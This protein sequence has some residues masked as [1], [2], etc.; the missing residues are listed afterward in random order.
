MFPSLAALRFDNTLQISRTTKSS[1]ANILGLDVMKLGYI[2]ITSRVFLG[3]LLLC[4]CVCTFSHEPRTI[5]AM[6]QLN[7]AGV[8]MCVCVVCI[9]KALRVNFIVVI[10]RYINTFCIVLFCINKS[11]QLM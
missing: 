10:W 5:S 8:G 4:V 9:L 1:C 6:R 11:K 2:T 3:L 7:S